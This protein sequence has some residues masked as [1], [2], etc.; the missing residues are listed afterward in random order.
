MAATKNIGENASLCL[1][2]MLW[3][4]SETSLSRWVVAVAFV[5]ISSMIF[6]QVSFTPIFLRALMH[7]QP[8][9]KLFDSLHIQ[10]KAAADIHLPFLSVDLKHAR[11][12]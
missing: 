3:I 2:P 4:G 7:V 1:T 6:T 10:H 5:Y 11:D 8:N 12:L 9:Q